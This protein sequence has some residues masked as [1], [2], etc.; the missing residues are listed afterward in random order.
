MNHELTASVLAN[1][2]K[3]GKF[4][5]PTRNAMENAVRLLTP[6]EPEAY[7]TNMGVF[8]TCGECG[9]QITSY[10]KFCS[11]CGRPVKRT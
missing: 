5:L 3:H 2:L 11:E 4:N 6:V 7:S 8:Y 10:D 1:L 9:G